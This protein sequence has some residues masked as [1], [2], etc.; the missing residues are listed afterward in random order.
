M[1]GCSRALQA[2]AFQS[3]RPHQT[4]KKDWTP[5]PLFWD[6][7]AGVHVSHQFPKGRAGPAPLTTAST[8]SHGTAHE[9]LLRRVL[10]RAPPAMQIHCGESLRTSRGS[11]YKLGLSKRQCLDRERERESGCLASLGPMYAEQKKWKAGVRL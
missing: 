10:T 5:G 6:W 8:P 11:G 9:P 7:D 1:A 2:L 4:T 3:S